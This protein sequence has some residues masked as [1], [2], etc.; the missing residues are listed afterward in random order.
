LIKAI[1]DLNFLMAAHSLRSFDWR[2]LYPADVAGYHSPCPSG[3]SKTIGE[4]P[5]LL[6]AARSLREA[7]CFSA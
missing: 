4:D 3:K 6:M 7:I 2:R 5:I 1:F